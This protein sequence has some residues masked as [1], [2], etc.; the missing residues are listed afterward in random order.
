M[1]YMQF[2]SESDADLGLLEI[3]HPN[4]LPGWKSDTPLL[5]DSPEEFS[6][7][8]LYLHI[9]TCLTAVEKGLIEE[10]ALDPSIKSIMGTEI[11]PL[12]FAA[13]IGHK[14][15]KH[16]LGKYY[17]ETRAQYYFPSSILG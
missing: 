8:L 16:A 5:K 11:G 1:R 2:L 15:L 6:Q 3:K 14:K 4:D 12:Q 17:S 13:K 9:N 7:R 10:E